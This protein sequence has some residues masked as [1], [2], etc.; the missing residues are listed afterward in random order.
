MSLCS[1]REK[2]ALAEPVKAVALAGA[3]PRWGGLERKGPALGASGRGGVWLSGPGVGQAFVPHEGPERLPTCA[4]AAH[5][6]ASPGAVGNAQA[7]TPPRP[8]RT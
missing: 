7:R 2:V 5:L 3:G 6:A 1:G 4:L 8:A